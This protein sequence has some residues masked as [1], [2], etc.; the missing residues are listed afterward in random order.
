MCVPKL[1]N[2]A[3]HKYECQPKKNIDFYNLW[4]DDYY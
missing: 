3:P 1:K 4:G 2:F